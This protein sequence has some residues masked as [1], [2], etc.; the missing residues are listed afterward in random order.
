MNA[1]PITCPMCGEFY[2]GPV[3]KPHRHE[4]F[5][6]ACGEM[7]EIDGNP[8]LR[9]PFDRPFWSD[10]YR[11]ALED[12]RSGEISAGLGTAMTVIVGA[13]TL[14]VM[15]VTILSVIV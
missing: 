3:T 9:R 8:E 11:I 1:E 7:L 15:L 4:V 2:D 10:Q 13:V 6:R 12:P 14:L 5:C